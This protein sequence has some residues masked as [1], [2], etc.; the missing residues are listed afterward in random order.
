[1]LKIEFVSSLPGRLV[2][3]KN[4]SG[5]MIISYR[6]WSQLTKEQRISL[7]KHYEDHAKQA[8]ADSVYNRLLSATEKRLAEALETMNDG[9]SMHEMDLDDEVDYK[10]ALKGCE[11]E[12]GQY[13]QLVTQ[14]R[15][16]WFAAF[17]PDDFVAKVTTT[18]RELIKLLDGRDID[19]PTDKARMSVPDGDIKVFVDEAQHVPEALW[20]TVEP[21]KDHV[22][23]GYD[24]DTQ[25][26]VY[27][28]ESWGWGAS[29]ATAR[30]FTCMKALELANSTNSMNIDTIINVCAVKEH[31]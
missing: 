10:D 25:S 22:I 31:D 13:R 30:R 27:W 26:T 1:M 24:T 28:Q 7:L 4:E 9:R 2:C 20:N 17:D 16:H 23:R 11:E 14:L 12:L 6:E 15:D 18:M 19:V 8:A 21:P 3:E 29:L 5:T